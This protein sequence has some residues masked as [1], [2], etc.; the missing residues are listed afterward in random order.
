M[1]K[2]IKKEKKKVVLYFTDEMGKDIYPFLPA[3]T[4]LQKGKPSTR[5]IPLPSLSK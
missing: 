3:Y 4:G 2:K 5:T 1:E